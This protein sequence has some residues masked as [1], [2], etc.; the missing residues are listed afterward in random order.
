MGKSPCGRRGAAASARCPEVSSRRPPGPPTESHLEDN[1]TRVGAQRGPPQLE[2]AVVL[3]PLVEAHGRS[4]LSLLVRRRGGVGGAGDGVQLLLRQGAGRQAP[5]PSHA[6]W[7]AQAG[8]RP[9]PATQWRSGPTARSRCA[10]TCPSKPGTA[11]RAGARRRCR[12]QSQH[13][14][15]TQR[16]W[17]PGLGR[18][19]ARGLTSPP[20]RRHSPA[21]S[22]GR[23]AGAQW[24]VGPRSPPPAQRRGAASRASGG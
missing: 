5:S 18:R 1:A 9:A 19:R 23:C 3:H 4:Q 15:S 16:G 7:A 22:L 11:R 24:R 8:C 14:P 6:G 17:S 10:R 2:V 13:S 20:A 12:G 21:A